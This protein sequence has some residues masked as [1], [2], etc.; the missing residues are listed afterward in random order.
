MRNYYCKK[1]VERFYDISTDDLKECLKIEQIKNEMESNFA[2]RNTSDG[3]ITTIF[4]KS[5]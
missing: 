4:E 3:G 2:M 5:N 1:K